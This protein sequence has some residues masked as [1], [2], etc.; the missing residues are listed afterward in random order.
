MTHLPM[1]FAYL[2]LS[3]TL[4]ASA[5]PWT[6]SEG[7]TIEAEYISSD[8]KSVVLNVSGRDVTYPLDKLSEADREYIAAR[9]ADTPKPRTG[10]FNG[11]KIDTRLFPEVD[12]YW[13]E[14]DRKSVRQAFESG[15]FFPNSNEGTYPE[16]VARDQ[17]RDTCQFYVPAAYDGSEPYGLLLYI[18]SGDSG[19]IPREWHGVLDELKLIA[20]GADN[21]GNDQPMMSRVQRSVDAFATAQKHYRIDPARCLVTGLSGGGHMAM[22][23]GALFPEHFL[24]AISHA[25]QSYLPGERSPG[26][27]PGLTTRDFKRGER[28]KMRWIV[29]SGDKDF[30]YPV[31]KETSQAWEKER[32]TYRFLDV[33][34]MAHTNAAAAFMKEAILWVMER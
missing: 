7:K 5:R 19:E 4:T 15:E 3:F 26:H 28:A 30:N 8:S 29:V 11:F 9:V 13:K 24:G 31:I 10:A 2:L 34:G 17:A 18:H 14:S 12:D 21:V 32:L 23:T 25:A 6:N 1:R 33:P 27:F 16:W 22:L 20:V